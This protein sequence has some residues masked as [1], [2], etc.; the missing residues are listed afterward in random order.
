[1]KLAFVLVFHAK[2]PG[3]HAFDLSTNH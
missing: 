1:L 2:F 3:E